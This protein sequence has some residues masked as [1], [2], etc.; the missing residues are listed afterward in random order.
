[1]KVLLINGSPHR[2]GCTYT[3]LREVQTTLEKH[4]VST[5]LLWIGSG[6]VAGCTAC[7]ACRKQGTCIFGDAVNDI[8]AR[9][10]EFDGLVAGSPVYYAGPSGQMTAFM[11]RLFYV[12]GMKMKWKAAAAVVS[13]R[14]GGASAAFD[15]VNKYFLMNNMYV[16]GSQYWNQVH[17]NS[18]D[19]VIQD[20]EGM[21]TMRTLGENMAYL[22]RALQAARMEGVPLPQHESVVRTN[23]IR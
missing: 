16:V 9:I 11:D 22:L 3:A 8:A 5:E 13:C 6:P 7:G 12:S 15:V 20:E 21:Q 4:G 10:D 19:E 14:R 2:T 23:F 1:M 18:P 17:G